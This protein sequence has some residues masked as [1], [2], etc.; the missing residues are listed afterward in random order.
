MKYGVVSQKRKA[1]VPSSTVIVAADLAHRMLLGGT[2][3][4]F[5]AS[6]DWSRSSIRKSRCMELQHG[7]DSR[8]VQPI[9][10]YYLNSTSVPR[11]FSD[12]ALFRVKYLLFTH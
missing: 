3:L 5:G 8:P 1:T 4:V 9:T 7:G 2:I 12:F 10:T 11:L 6:I